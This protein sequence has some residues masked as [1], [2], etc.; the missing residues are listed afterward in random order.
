MKARSAVSMMSPVVADADRRVR[1]GSRESQLL[2]AQARNVAYAQAAQGQIGDGVSL[3]CDAL[4]IDPSSVELLSDVGALLL[5]AGQLTDA[6]LY[7]HRA[8]ELSPHHAPSLYTL[9]FALSGL[10]EIKSA[11]EVL[12]TLSQG[13]ALASLTRDTPDLVPLVFTELHRLQAAG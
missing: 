5:S 12:T 7:S 9:G 11:I 4:V 10:G 13:E 3:L 1:P 8:I 6:A 2:L